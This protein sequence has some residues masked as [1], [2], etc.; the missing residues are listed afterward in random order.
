MSRNRLSAWTAIFSENMVWVAVPSRAGSKT[1]FQSTLSHECFLFTWYL[2][3]KIISCQ[4]CECSRTRLPYFKCSMAKH[5]MFD[6]YQIS[7][8][9]TARVHAKTQP[10]ERTCFIQSARQCV[11]AS[12]VVLRSVLRL[13]YLT[14]FTPC[15][16]QLFLNS[17]NLLLS[18]QLLCN[19]ANKPLVNND[20]GLLLFKD[21]RVL[22]CCY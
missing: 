22:R 15:C 13:S 5:A 12:I 19:S 18:F 8:C 1:W 17:Q 16:R 11:F 7:S 6:W 2:L 4:Q 14:Q 20:C 3:A 9:F 21:G 10:I